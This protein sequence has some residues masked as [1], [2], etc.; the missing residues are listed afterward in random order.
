MIFAA[1]RT[2]F[3]FA[4]FCAGKSCA[5]ADTLIFKDG[6]RVVGKLLASEN[7]TMVFRSSRFGEIRVKSS[8]ARVER[9]SGDAHEV[10][11]PP[12]PAAAAV[13]SA[14]ANFTSSHRLVQEGRSAWTGRVAIGTESV[15]DASDQKSL[16]L[17]L[18]LERKWK[19]DQLHNELHYEYRTVDGVKQSDDLKISGYWKHG[20]PD[21]LFSVCRSSIEWNRYAILDNVFTPYVVVQ[22]ELGFGYRLLNQPTHKISTGISENLFNGR[23]IHSE[24]RV[25]ARVES[26]FVEM[27]L[28]LPFD[29]KLIQRSVFYYSTELGRSGVE[30][31]V[32]LS[33][34][35]TTTLSLGL[36][37]QYQRNLPDLRL[38]AFERL[39]LLLGYDF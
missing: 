23:A 9:E 36:Q 34:R 17:D 6:D 10:V 37:H 25:R 19:K 32:E 21:R 22:Q 20:M 39:R 12:S 16:V 4:L 5:Q 14:D 26:A 27:D 8:E 31:N 28:K 35:L 24:R 11:G 33:R 13:P 15:H 29:T 18:R 30:S 1:R 38:Q 3:F 2:L 7:G